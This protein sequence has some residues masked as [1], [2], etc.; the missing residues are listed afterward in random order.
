MS[1]SEELKEEKT[2]LIERLKIQPD[3]QKFLQIPVCDKPPLESHFKD[4]AIDA[5]DGIEHLYILMMN[6][7]SESRFW[8][9]VNYA[10]E[11]FTVDY[12]VAPD[13]MYFLNWDGTNP[14]GNNPGNMIDGTA[15]I[16]N[17]QSVCTQL[18]SV[19]DEDD[20]L[21]VFITDHGRGYTGPNQHS[22][23]QQSI[24]GYLDG[25]ASVDPGDEQDYLEGDLNKDGKITGDEV[26]DFDGDGN[27]PYDHST[28]PDAAVQR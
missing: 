9:D 16:T 25:S 3:E 6:G 18:A 14:D 22:S 19:V 24:Y 15:T 11:V 7:G 26:A 1:D 10:Y 17:V 8:D 12:N 27:Q 23:Y 5:G 4:M 20:L 2:L 28:G 21:Y 13:D